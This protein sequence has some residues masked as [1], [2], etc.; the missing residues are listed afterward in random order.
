MFEGIDGSGKSTL[1]E[2]VC[3]ELEAMGRKV[4]PTQEP[5]RDEIGT[6]IRNGSVKGISQK[7]EALL[8]VA[9]RA[10]H[11]ERIRKLVGEGYVVVCDR[12]FASTVA[13]QSAPLKGE[14]LDRE[15]L[16]AMNEPV[17]MTPDATFLLD[18][19][20]DA[21]MNRVT[22][23][24][25]RSK[26]EDAEFQR[27]V[28]DNYLGLAEEFNFIIINAARPRESILED[29]MARIREII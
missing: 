20:A 5:T 2:G 10:V 9:D 8:F 24:G 26:F 4:F 15:W 25:D 7:A 3:R 28:R 22:A 18:I 14:C 16:I 27:K 11:T 17:I 13:Y 12:Y 21:S 19:D 23:R 6:F 29:V 1:C